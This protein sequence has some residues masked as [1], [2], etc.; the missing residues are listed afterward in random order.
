MEINIL[1]CIEGAK[2]AQGLTVIID[3]FRAFSLECYLFHQGAKRIIPIGN[4][5]QAFALKAE[6]PDWCLFGERKG[7]KVDGCDFG[8]SPNEIAHLDFSN[9]TIIHTTSAGTQGI[10]N[11]KG[12]DEIVTASLVNAK[13]VARYIQQKNPDLV[14]IVAMGNQGVCRAD[15]DLLCA[16]Y[17]KALLERK[18]F[19]IDQ[20]VEALKKG[21]GAKF[22]DPT[23]L[24]FP[25][26]DFA[27][28]T[29]V[30]HFDFVIQ[31]TK[32]GNRAYRIQ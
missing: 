18:E 28:C 9:K 6:H 24:I 15:E 14:S 5:N 17:I 20:E 8:N 3:V 1:E 16:Q 31:V 26:A 27:L 12:A 21:A 7:A 22:F 32:N 29:N 11:A 25:E 30:D 19:R 4:L 13:A 2:Q 10:V 23:N